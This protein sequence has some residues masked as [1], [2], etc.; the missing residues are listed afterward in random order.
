MW[1][2]APQ[3][4]PGAP[5]RFT[6][7]LPPS[8]PFSELG[9]SGIALSPDGR[10][11]VYAADNP[12][13][14]V[15]RRLA[16]SNVE[17]LRGAEGGGAPFFSPDGAW[18][19]FFADGKL[20]RVPLDG[21]IAVTVSEDALVG[22]GTWGDD[23][24]IVFTTQLGLYQVALDGGPAQLVLKA[25]ER[26]HSVSRGSSRVCRT[27]LVRRGTPLAESHIEAVDLQKRTTR[28]LAVEGTN[29]QFASPDTLLFERQGGVWAGP[30]I[31]NSWQ[32]SV[33]Q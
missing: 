26:D 24:T 10:T 32:R 12:L 9:A 1:R 14:L 2:L 30:S 13:G 23:G 8:A 15:V 31:P 19:G 11:V 6:L 33:R 25:D 4:I 20:K 5:I 22:R 21:G 17:R 16:R 3:A 28:A 27:V 18:V 7:P 29:P